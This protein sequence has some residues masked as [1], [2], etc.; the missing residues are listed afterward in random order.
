MPGGD[1]LKIELRF[2]NRFSDANAQS[3][4]SCV[5]QRN[6]FMVL[7]KTELPHALGGNAAGRQVRYSARCKLETRVR[8]IDL[9]CNDRNSE[10][11]NRLY[12]RVRQ[13]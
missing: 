11:M 3:I 5:I 8:N 9:I 6:I 4:L 12:R 2:R 13:R 7:K 10:R 1:R